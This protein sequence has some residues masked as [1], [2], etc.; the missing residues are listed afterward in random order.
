MAARIHVQTVLRPERRRR[1]LRIG[2]V[3]CADDVAPPRGPPEH[4]AGQGIA[5]ASDHAAEW[6]LLRRVGAREQEQGDAF[7]VAAA[8]H[9]GECIREAVDVR[10]GPQHVVTAA[11]ERQVRRLQRQRGLKLLA[12]DRPDQ[13]AANSEVRVLDGLSGRICPALCDKVRPTTA[14]A[15][16]E[17]VA[18]ALGK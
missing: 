3:E 18:D 10:S 16:G 1:Q 11:V 4:G 6:E 14:G 15:I 12:D 7:F 8:Q 5:A 13:L 2:P 17:L 9:L